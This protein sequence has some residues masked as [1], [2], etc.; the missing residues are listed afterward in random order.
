MKRS[1]ELVIGRSGDRKRRL[2]AET[3]RRGEQLSIHHGDTEARRN[4]GNWIQNAWKVFGAVLQEIFDESAY[5][6]F[7]NRAQAP[8][9]KESYHAFL[10]ERESAIAQ[11]PRCC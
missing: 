6:R 3:R 11:K 5:E 9:S 7:L 1:G 8:R 4:S 2:T 10:R